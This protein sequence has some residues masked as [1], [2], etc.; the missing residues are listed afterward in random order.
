[1]SIRKDKNPI[2]DNTG[3]NAGISN[4]DRDVFFLVGTLG[5]EVQRRCMVPAN[6]SILYPV[7]NYELNSHDDPKFMTDQE[8]IAAVQD[9]IDDIVN[10]KATV[11]G[12]DAQIRRIR[13]DPLIFN[14]VDCF[15]SADNGHLR[16]EAILKRAS[17]DGYW[18][19]LKPLPKGKH[20]LYFSGS[21]SAATRNVKASYKIYVT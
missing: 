4:N 19:F 5:G 2:V 9:D 13:S 16:S 11:D 10:L 7:I 6:K 8:M 15:D 14:L 17:S 1:M 3:E 12:R 18:V 20:E 21:C